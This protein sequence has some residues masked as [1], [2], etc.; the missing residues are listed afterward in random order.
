VLSRLAHLT[1]KGEDIFKYLRSE[2]VKQRARKL[3]KLGKYVK[4]EEIKVFG[5]SLDAKAILEDVINAVSDT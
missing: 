4:L 2:E 1:R 3:G 5:I